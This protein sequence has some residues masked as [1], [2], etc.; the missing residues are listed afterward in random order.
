MIEDLKTSLIKEIKAAKPTLDNIPDETLVNETFLFPSTLRLTYAGYVYT[1]L[2]FKEY[3]FE[4]KGM[5]PSNTNLIAL[6]K[7]MKFPYYITYS[8]LILF[9]E[10]DAILI[11]LYGSVK[12]YLD[13]QANI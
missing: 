13:S 6:G 10:T 4:F 5:A 11:A 7:V 8:R 12:K 2:V 9:C 1:K 3:I